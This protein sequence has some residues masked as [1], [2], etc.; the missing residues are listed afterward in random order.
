M[1]DMRLK[2]L[3]HVVNDEGLRPLVDIVYSNFHESTGNI[4]FAR[5]KGLVARVDES[6]GL[7]RVIN[8]KISFIDIYSIDG[9]VFN[10]L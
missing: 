3:I 1:L 4:E 7:L 2:Y 10:N 6:A 5:I 9:E 8:S